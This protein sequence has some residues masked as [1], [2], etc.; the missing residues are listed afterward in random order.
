[1]STPDRALCNDGLISRYE[2]LR[3]QALGLPCEI[4]RGQGLTLL[5]RSAH[6]SVDASMGPVRGH[7]C[8][9]AAAAW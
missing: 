6:E 5:M 1:M 9:A 7:G 3:Q 4:P 8:T 2:D